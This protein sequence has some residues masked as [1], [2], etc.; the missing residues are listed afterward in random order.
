MALTSMLGQASTGLWITVGLLFL[1]TQLDSPFKSA[2]SA[3]VPDILPWE[4]YVLCTAVTQITFQ[5][6]LVSGFALG[7]LVVASLG[8]RA[9]LL[10]DAATFAVSALLVGVGVRKRPAAIDVAGA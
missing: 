6:G 9:A 4:K 2:R 8:V 7:G 3:L 10:A 5:V 1:V